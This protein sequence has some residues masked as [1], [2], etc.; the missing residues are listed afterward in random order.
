[1]R[2]TESDQLK[3]EVDQSIKITF[4]AEARSRAT[5][6]YFGDVIS[7][8]TTYNINSMVLGQQVAFRY[9]FRAFRISSFMDSSLS[10]SPLLGQDEKH[11]KEREH[12][13]FFLTSSLCVTAYL[14]NSSNSTII[15]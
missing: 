11:T 6:E 10:R 12:A 14:S 8:D 4:W 5:C 7:F 1:M 15:A 13:C 9:F 3:L 2:K